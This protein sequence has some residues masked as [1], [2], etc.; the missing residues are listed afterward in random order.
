MESRFLGEATGSKGCI[1]SSS[2]ELLEFDLVIC[3]PP[4]LVVGVAS[5]DYRFPWLFVEPHMPEKLASTSSGLHLIML[6]HDIVDGDA[7]CLI[8]DEGQV[9]L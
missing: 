6:K 5:I 2:E 3:V 8:G 4:L 9:L 7:M 1:S